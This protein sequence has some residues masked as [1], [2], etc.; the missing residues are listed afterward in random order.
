VFRLDDFYR[1]EGDPA[2]PRHAEL[3]I[4]DWD[5]P[6]SW[7]ADRAVAALAELLDTGRTEMP[8]YDLSLSRAVGRHEVEAGAKVSVPVRALSVWQTNRQKT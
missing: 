4:V 5:H 7:D 2:V 1:D 6:D 8:V 3:G